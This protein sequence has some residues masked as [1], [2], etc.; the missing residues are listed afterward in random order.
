MRFLKS[1]SLLFLLIGSLIAPSLSANESIENVLSNNRLEIFDLSRKKADEDSSILEKDWINQVIYKLTK[2]YGEEYDTLKS[3]ISISQPIFKSGGIYKAINYAKASKKYAHLDITLQKKEMIKDALSF[4]FQI[5]KQNI[6][7]EKQNLLIKNAVI[8]VERKKEQVLNG[9]IDTSYLDNAILDANTKKNTLLDLNYE[10]L[11]LINNFSNL[12]NAAHDSIN[13]PTLSIIDKNNFLRKNL[14]VLKITAD[15]EKKYQ[16]KGMSISKYLPT[17]NVTYDYYNHHDQDGL[18]STSTD[19]ASTYGF[20]ITIPLDTKVFNDI[21][22]SKLDYLKAKVELQNIII[23]EQNFLKLKLAKLNMYDAKISLAK[24]DFNLYTS[25]L[26]DLSI[27][28][29]AGLNARADVDIMKNSK[30]I[31]SLD[32]KIFDIDKQIE[33]LDIYARIN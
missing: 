10:K 3:T 30:K 15:I 18:S 14:N 12:S 2:E 8:D 1:K 33:L 5:K 25:L 24:D 7:I 19:S 4:L 32:I 6:K 29:E 23:E 31:K 27:S 20:N 22:S 21:E 17:L 28:F 11:T 13:L 26:E 16:F 9:L